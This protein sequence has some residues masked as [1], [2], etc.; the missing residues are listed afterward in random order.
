MGY[1]P[2][3][4]YQR[5]LPGT[6]RLLPDISWVA[7]PFTGVIVVETEA[8]HRPA[9]GVGSTYGGTSVAC[10]MFSGLWAIANQ[11]AGVP[12]GQAASYLYSM[13]AG[14]ITDIVPFGSASNVIAN[15]QNSSTVPDNF[16]ALGK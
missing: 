5:A 6:W 11:A 9:A 10:P 2:N 7:D 1:S 13:P 14:A 3:P 15:I 4:R 8:G 16:D 12:L